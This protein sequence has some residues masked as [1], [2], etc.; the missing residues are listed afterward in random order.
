M[1]TYDGLRDLVP[2]VQFKKHGKD[3]WRSVTFSYSLQIVPNRATHHRLLVSILLLQLRKISRSY[4]VPTR[5][6]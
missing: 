2:F 4:L 1:D 3:P 6:Y 5:N